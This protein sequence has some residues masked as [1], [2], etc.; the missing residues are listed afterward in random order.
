[1]FMSFCLQT[2]QMWDPNVQSLLHFW[3]TLSNNFFFGEDPIKQKIFYI[4]FGVS[5]VGSP[6]YPD[7][8]L[9]DPASHQD[10]CGSCR[11]R[12]RDLGPRSLARYQWATTST[13]ENWVT[14]KKFH[15]IQYFAAFDARCW[16]STF[17]RKLPMSANAG[18]GLVRIRIGPDPPHCC[19]L[20]GTTV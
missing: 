10:H 13:A 9:N 11:I 2:I 6:L 7:I 5:G 1:M 18:F 17:F 4:F 16:E 14:P 12:I 20:P 19:P 8:L 3:S 15:S